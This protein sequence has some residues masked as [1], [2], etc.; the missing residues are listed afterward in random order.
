MSIWVNKEKCKACGNCLQVC[1]GG[2]IDSDEYHKAYIKYPQDCWGCAACLK[3]CR[4]EAIRYYLAPDIGGR[5]T[6]LYVKNDRNLMHWY[7]VKDKTVTQI[8]TDKLEANKY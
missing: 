8:T 5:G 6:Y 2:L 3:E 4:Y 7:I 1:P